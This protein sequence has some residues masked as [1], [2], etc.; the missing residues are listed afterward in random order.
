MPFGSTYRGKCHIYFL[1]L[2]SL[3]IYQ[4]RFR[5]GVWRKYFFVKNFQVHKF[6]C[7]GDH[8][9]ALYLR[10]F[11][12]YNLQIIYLTCATET[13]PKAYKS[14]WVQVGVAFLKN[15]QVTKMTRFSKQIKSLIL[16]E[17]GIKHVKI[18]LYVLIWRFRVKKV[19]LEIS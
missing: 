19:I 4:K 9:G 18:V 6:Q 7:A 1:F 13:K 12:R 3:G 16:V 17:K 2:Q 15:P 8:F 14:G 5:M 10:Q 11:S